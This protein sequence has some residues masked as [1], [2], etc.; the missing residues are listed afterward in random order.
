MKSDLQ[1]S[2]I[3]GDNQ[4]VD[5]PRLYVSVGLIQFCLAVNHKYN[6]KYFVSGIGEST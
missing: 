5:F 3:V 4:Q 2:M 6:L 1:T